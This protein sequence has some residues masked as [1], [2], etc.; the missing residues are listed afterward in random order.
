MKIVSLLKSPTKQAPIVPVNH[1]QWTFNLGVLAGTEI[2]IWLES[3]LD[4]FHSSDN[5]LKI[6]IKN[7]GTKVATNL[8]L[9][10][11]TSK[12]IKILN[13]RQ[14]FGTSKNHLLIKRIPSKKSVTAIANFQLDARAENAHLIA[15]ISTK[16]RAGQ[17]HKLECDLNLFR[18]ISR[19]GA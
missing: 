1:P 2:S 3:T 14:V 12:N 8:Y 7:E 13:R 18:Q 19:L 11:K 6:T 10:I 9:G 15:E 5:S 16:E 4:P 17:V